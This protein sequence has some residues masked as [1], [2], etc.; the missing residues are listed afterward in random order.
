MDILI[1]FK[2]PLSLFLYHAKILLRVGDHIRQGISIAGMEGQG[3]HGNH[4]IQIDFHDAVIEG[5]AS[6]FHFLITLRTAVNL[7]I[8]P[9]VLIGY[10]HGGKA[11]GL[12]GHG[13]DAVSKIHG[14]AL[15]AGAHKFQNLI[16][17]EI[18]LKY[19]PDQA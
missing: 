3:D 10:P 17:H 11:G 8:L 18:I 13:V 14:Q 16:F 5:L 4:R 12:G 6:G 7:K 15:H 9:S 1:V 2:H 19:R